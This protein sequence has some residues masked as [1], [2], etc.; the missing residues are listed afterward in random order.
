MNTDIALIAAAGIPS[1]HTD[2]ERDPAQRRAT[3]ALAVLLIFSAFILLAVG[4][5]NLRH[6]SDWAIADWL[7][8]YSGGFV[9]R[10]LSGSGALLLRPLH[11]SPPIAILLLQLVLYTWILLA[12][13][14]LLRRARWTLALLALVFS[15][16][17]L[18]FPLMD[19][20]FAFRKE[21]FFFALLGGLLLL[22]RAAAPTAAMITLLTLGCAICVLSHEALVIFFPYLFAALLLGLPRARHAL[23]CAALPALLTAVLLVLVSRHPGMLRLAAPSAL[24]LAAPLQIHLRACAEAPS[25][26]S[27][28]LRRM[29]AA[30]SR[31]VAFAEHY[32]RIIPEL[33]ALTLLPVLL[34]LCSL[35][36]EGHRRTVNIVT[37]AML[38]ASIASTSLFFYGTD[39]TRWIYI[40]AFSLMLLLAFA[41][42]QRKRVLSA[43]PSAALFSGTSLRRSLT[44]TALLLY[45]FGWNLSLYQPRVPMGGLIHYIVKQLRA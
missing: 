21:I 25:L 42:A 30:R 15:P 6:G 3:A 10:G 44:V 29:P 28:T 14:L 31:R 40:H 2:A 1:S 37:L 32:N 4:L 33:V 39:W 27:R 5:S 19:P 43:A 45:V 7:I 17:T 11:L 12:V 26:I 38:A 34:Q 18:H 16:A 9:R 35:W 24:P 23:I 22:L 13:W 41:A 20:N 36:R 8:N